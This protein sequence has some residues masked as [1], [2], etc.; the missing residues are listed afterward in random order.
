MLFVALA[1]IAPFLSCMQTALRNARQDN[2]GKPTDAQ[3]SRRGKQ[4]VN[5]TYQIR[6][7][8]IPRGS[9]PSDIQQ[10]LKQ[11]VFKRRLIFR[12][13]IISSTALER[14]TLQ[15]GVCGAADSEKI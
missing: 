8:L 1:A 2:H 15:A 12:K 10:D 4:G 14:C 11:F 13:A 7:E 9:R 3:F 5:Q 6:S